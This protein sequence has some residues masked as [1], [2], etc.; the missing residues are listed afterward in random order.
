MDHC[1]K[2]AIPTTAR[3]EAKNSADYV[4]PCAGGEGAVM[5]ACLYVLKRLGVNYEL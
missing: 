5:D 3:I 4:T 2:K 1:A